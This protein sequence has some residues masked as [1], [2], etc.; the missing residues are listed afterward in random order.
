[1]LVETDPQPPVH[2]LLRRGLHNAPGPEVEPGVPAALDP[3]KTFRVESNSG[4]VG[5]GRRTAFAHWVT[6]P[7]N[8]L[9]ARVM[10]NRIWQQHFGVGLVTTPDNIGQS[11][12]RPSHPE[13][14][15]Y[16]AREFIR[17]AGVSKLSTG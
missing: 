11:G 12:A 16:L 14:L 15:D 13:L 1:M 7:D 5:T 3:R 9:F 8:P 10:V 17:S 2:H 4:G 6:T